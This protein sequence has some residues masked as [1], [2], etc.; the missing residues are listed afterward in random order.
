MVNPGESQRPRI[1]ANEN[2]TKEVEIDKS[3]EE[4][5]NAAPQPLKLCCSTRVPRVFFG[6]SPKNAAAPRKEDA[7]RRSKLPFIATPLGFFVFEFQNGTSS[8]R[9]QFT[10]NKKYCCVWS[11]EIAF[12]NVVAPVESK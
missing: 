9:T 3:F 5:A 8:Q 10:C 4:C 6:V 7:H 11:P 2:A 12:V 1:H